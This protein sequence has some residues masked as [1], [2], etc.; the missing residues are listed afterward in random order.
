MG[1]EIGFTSQE[2]VGSTFWFQL[3]LTLQAPAAPAEAPAEPRPLRFLPAPAVRFRNRPERTPL[4]A[5]P[6]E[7]L[8]RQAPVSSC[9]VLV[10]DDNVI[11]QEVG[12]ALLGALGH[13]C[14][15][16]VDGQEAVAMV[17]QGAYDLILMDM[18]MPRVDGVTA[19]RMIRALG[20]PRSRVPIIAM[21]A[22]AME[23][24]RVRCLEAGMDDFLPKPVD[25][26]RLQACSSAGSTGLRATRRFRRTARNWPGRC[27]GRTRRNQPELCRASQPG[28]RRRRKYLPFRVGAGQNEGFSFFSY[29]PRRSGDDRTIETPPERRSPGA[30]GKDG[31]LRRL[32]HAGSIPAGSSPST[33]PSAPG[34]DCST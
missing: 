31:G 2:G 28:W 34:S 16:A 27:R 12:V 10:V 20:G 19:T 11:N 13:P 25:R 6:L 7:P 4:P 3:P 33:S 24:D 32:G 23:S 30:G 26:R 18:Q 5:V 15:V 17:E 29:N 22:N 1:G 21:T 8:E 9:R 14:D